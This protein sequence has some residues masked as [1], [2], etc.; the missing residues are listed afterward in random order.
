MITFEKMTPAQAKW[1]ALIEYYF[2]DTYKSGRITHAQLVTAH[3]HFLELRKE[4][5]K[6]KTGWPIWLITN[7]AI[8]RGVYQLPTQAESVPQI[9]PDTTH[10]FYPD[11]IKELKEFGVV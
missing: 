6:Y 3:N 7:N 4:D 1:L 5:K 10:E 9:D 2:A 11:Y 8:E